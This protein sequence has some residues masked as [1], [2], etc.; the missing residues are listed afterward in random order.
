MP[1]ARYTA[2]FL[3]VPSSRI[4]SRSA[5]KYTIGYIGSSGRCCHCSTSDNTSSVIVEIRSGDTLK[6]YSC[7]R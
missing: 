5:S 3:T 4:F 6:P 2:L 1:N 7:C